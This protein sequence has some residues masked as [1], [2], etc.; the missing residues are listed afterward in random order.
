MK[1]TLRGKQRTFSSLFR[2]AFDGF[3]DRSK[4]ALFTHALQ[5]ILRFVEIGP[6]DKQMNKV[7]FRL[8]LGFQ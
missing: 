2:L 4:L 8:Y 6:N 7:A 5:A 1:G 3:S